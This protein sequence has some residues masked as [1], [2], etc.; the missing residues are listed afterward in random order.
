MRNVCSY[1]SMIRWAI[2]AM[3]WWTHIEYAC[4]QEPPPNP[5]KFID[6]SF[7]N[8]SP[9][10][11][12]TAADQTTLV[13]LMYDHERDSANRAAGHVHIRLE[14]AP[15]SKIKL[16]FRNLDNIYNGRP[17]SVAKE[18]HRLV[19]SED[20]KHWQS[21]A[22]EVLEN[23]VR[24]DV[25]LKSSQLYVA[26][27]EPY[28]LSDLSQLFE[29][30][31]GNSRVEL[32]S[33]GRTVEGRDLDLI[34]L[35]DAR[36]EHHVFV[37]ARAHPWEAGGNWIVE[38]L[39]QGALG[40]DGNS[41][42]LLEHCCLWILPMANKDGVARGRTRFNLLGKDLNRDWLVP[43]DQITAPENY[44]LE[45]WL[46]QRLN[47]GQRIDFALE[48][49]NDGNGSLH[50]TSPAETDRARYAARMYTFESL[51]REHTW[52]SVGATQ[53]AHS[54]G[55]LPN[56]WQTRFGI[57]GA[58]HEFNCQWIERLKVG[59]LKEHWIEYGQGLVTVF[60]RFL[61]TTR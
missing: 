57:D 34:R 42:K 58:V 31:K 18:M 37:R 36:A 53:S 54:V 60:D 43:A 48:V 5:L 9:V 27:V 19:I 33:L 32:T 17:G 30:I 28:R 7:E 47:A 35:G 2:V 39:I 24:L 61:D 16:E 45:K 3:V 50:H 6:T 41:H 38:G 21:V 15:D 11:Y 22:T 10:W 20:G 23:R 4:A 26:R 25:Q 56:G 52:F 13:H 12:E 1:S 40:S 59:P 14:G 46:H 8:A 44:A 49:H 29:K 55:T 51:L